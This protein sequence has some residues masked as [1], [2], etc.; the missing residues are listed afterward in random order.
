MISIKLQIQFSNDFLCH[1]VF[2][3]R[4]KR[5]ENRRKRPAHCLEFACPSIRG[6]WRARVNRE[7]NS[8]YARRRDYI[9][10]IIR[11]NLYHTGNTRGII[12]PLPKLCKIRPLFSHGTFEVEV[13]FAIQRTPPNPRFSR[14]KENF[15]ETSR[16]CIVKAKRVSRIADHAPH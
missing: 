9:R 13:Y 10:Y 2:Y 5:C 7:I 15:S 8:D 6:T 12:L 1:G 16:G 14:T 4:I 3:L 11:M